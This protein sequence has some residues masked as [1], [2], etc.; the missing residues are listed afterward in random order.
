VIRFLLLDLDNTLYPADSG[1]WEAIGHR[2][3]LY[4]MERL[5]FHPDEVSER[6][7]AYLHLFGTTLNALRHYH[8]VDPDDF[9]SFVHDLPLDRYL[10][11]GPE[12]DSMLVRL[13]QQKVIFT[14]ADAS[15]AERVLE[16]L[17]IRRHF[18]QIIDIHSLEFICKPD[19]RAYEKVL[20]SV[21]ARP[22]E[23]LFADD[24]LQNLVPAM[25][26]GMTTVLVGPDAAAAG[27][28]YCIKDILQLEPL[29]QQHLKCR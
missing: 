9:L 2:I 29:M 8:H 13:P 19:P 5:G 4:M 10:P 12:L 14:N 27:A 25:V 6:R 17:G 18:E 15:H 26:M 3:N 11:A 23:C 22:E 21:G 16:R 7:D 24:S 20:Q 1:L 28:S